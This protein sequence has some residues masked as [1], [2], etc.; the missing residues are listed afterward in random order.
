MKQ[1]FTCTLLCFFTSSVFAQPLPSRVTKD[2]WEWSNAANGWSW[3]PT[4]RVSHSY[5][6]N[7]LLVQSLFDDSTTNGWNLEAKTDFVYN[8]SGDVLFQEHF[9]C[10]NASSPWENDYRESMTYD[11]NGLLIEFLRE[12]WYLNEWVNNVHYFYINDSATGGCLESTALLWN[13]NTLQWE[14]SGRMNFTLDSEGRQITWLSSPWNTNLQGWYPEARGTI[15]YT[16]SGKMHVYTSEQ[17]QGGNWVY[18]TRQT[19]TYNSDDRETLRLREAWSSGAWNQI[20]DFKIFY[21]NDQSVSYTVSRW[22]SNGV[23]EN[24][25]RERYAYG[26]LALDEAEQAEVVVFPNPVTDQLTVVFDTE[27]A[28]ALLLLTDLSGK[29]LSEQVVDGKQQQISLAEIPAGVYLLTI[30]T[31]GGTTTSTI[32][33]H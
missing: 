27:P 30:S 32:I 11:A 21:N 25:I 23:W 14:N 28:D 7:G 8:A 29:L 2:M 20:Y 1:L 24:S 33:K 6:G 5:D 10:L 12:R 18:V 17:L 3:T 4:S 26:A 31:D 9:D 19:Y 15:S 16:P 13:T 22:R